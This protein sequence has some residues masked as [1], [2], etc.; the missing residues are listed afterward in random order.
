MTDTS[1]EELIRRRREERAVEA[2][3]ALEQRNVQEFQRIMQE[4]ALEAAPRD[5]ETRML[6]HS[7]ELG[8]PGLSDSIVRA[9][10]A[11]ADT[12]EER[13]AAFNQVFP[14]GELRPAR[15]E[16]GNTF[17][18]FR[19]DPGEPWRK[20]DPGLGEKFEPLQDIA[21][22]ASAAAPIAGE[23]ATT[24]GAGGLIRRTVQPM[25]GAA[26]GEAVEEGA[27]VALGQQ[28]QTAGEV[29][30]QV[31]TEGLLAGI[32][33]MASEPLAGL[34]NVRRGAGILQLMPGAREAIEAQER[35]GLPELLPFQ[36]AED[37]IIRTT[38]TQAQALTTT[39]TDFIVRQQVGAT[40]RVRA[41]RDAPSA[42]PNMLPIFLRSRVKARENA[43]DEILARPNVELE[44]GGEALQKGL[45]EYDVLARAEIDDLFTAARAL[46][47]PQFDFASLDQAAQDMLEGFIVSDRGPRPTS[48]LASELRAVLEETRALAANPQPLVIPR[49][50]GTQITISVTD[51]LRALRERLWD[52]K[53]VDRGQISRRPQADAAFMWNRMTAALENPLNDSPDFVNAWQAANTRAA[54]R[55]Q[56]WDRAVIRATAKSEDPT[57]LAFSYARPRQVTNL[58]I[59]RETIPAE[60][61]RVFQDAAKQ[62]FLSDLPNLSQTLD[63]FDDPT[64]NMLMPSG[65]LSALRTVARNYDQFAGARNLSQ[66]TRFED[67]AGRLLRAGDGEVADSVTR[68]IRG[69][70]SPEGRSLRAA[71]LNNIY[72]QIVEVQGGVPSV[73][74][75]RLQTI[76]RGMER[77]GSSRF[78]I[79][80]D[81]QALQDVDRYLDIITGVPDVGTSLLRA[82][83]VKELRE[84]NVKAAFDIVQAY[85][86]GRLMTTTQGRQFLMGSGRDKLNFNN[87]RLLGAAGAT[88]AADEQ[89]LGRSQ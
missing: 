52:L 57:N 4:R 73:N 66:S 61:W 35:Q 37:P 18:I 71:I 82:S 69:P 2:P 75:G 16:A 62:Q 5:P 44:T 47:E 77:N 14:L 34:L 88:I 87:L 17:E 86:V 29:A 21:D 67:I 56:T 45:A 24:R 83:I 53:T 36:V 19:R 27:E 11:I 48:P 40:E 63:G 31:G 54:E 58:R 3:R 74:R 15:D 6:V 78:L 64:L 23:I 26:T 59:L 32:G 70:G 49:A 79:D 51:Q 25:I 46:D 20:F 85:T 9:R 10:V 22:F 76:L 7:S 41:L 28:R 8:E 12:R 84:L 89:A 60:N 33:S 50:D 13:L 1:F 38:G 65:E 81:R 39:M 55:F 42:D 72:D 30:G 43:L 80:A 68:T